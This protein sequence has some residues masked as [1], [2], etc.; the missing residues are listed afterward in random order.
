MDKIKVLH[1]Y[2]NIKLTCGVTRSILNIHNHTS[3]KVI[4]YLVFLGG[5]QDTLLSDKG[6]YFH[7]LKLKSRYSPFKIIKVF[8]F[9]LKFCTS[10]SISLIHSHHRYFDLLAYFVSKV[11]S[12]KTITSVH[13]ILRNRKLFSYK[14]DFFIAHSFAAKTNLIEEYSIKDNKIEVIYNSISV[15][16]FLPVKTKEQVLAELNLN[17]NMKIIL[18]IGTVSKRKGVDLLIKAFKELVKYR[19]DLKLVIIGNLEEDLKYSISREMNM[20][21]FFLGEIKNIYDY[22]NVASLV[23]LPS[24]TDTFP[25]VMLET[26]VSGKPFLG[27]DLEG[28]SEYIEDSENGLLFEPGN[29]ND[30]EHKINML[31]NSDDLCQSMVDKNYE[32]VAKYDHKI[33]IPQ[34]EN[35]YLSILKN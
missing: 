20:F 6:I 18:F 9:L 22:L 10:N 12:V 30:L 16:E 8:Y 5:D 25:F 32:K 11:I 31:L 7:N 14:S 3:D 35:V 19:N 13:S 17:S 4:N 34:I 29:A 1:L 28:I 33:I 21:I 2:T 24:R 23:V 15:S 26:A 27:A